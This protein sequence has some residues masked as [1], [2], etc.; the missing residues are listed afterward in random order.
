MFG[1][2]CSWFIDQPRPKIICTKTQTLANLFLFAPLAAR[3]PPRYRGTR[4]PPTWL[5]CSTSAQETWWAGASVTTTPWPS[6][7]LTFP[8]FGRSADPRKWVML[9]WCLELSGLHIFKSWTLV[10]PMSCCWYDTGYT[11]DQPSKMCKTEG[12][13]ANSLSILGFCEIF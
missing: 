3:T 9:I 10:H 13:N 5:P 11:D 12:S 6:F 8:Q 2:V 4:G 7:L 1:F